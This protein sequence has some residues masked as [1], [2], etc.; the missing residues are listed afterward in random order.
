[1]VDRG[2]DIFRLKLSA[3]I[4]RRRRGGRRFAPWV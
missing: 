3:R 2:A 4:G 1:V